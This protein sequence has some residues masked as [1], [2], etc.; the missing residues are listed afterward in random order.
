MPRGSSPKVP[1]LYIWGSEKANFEVDITE[2]I[3]EKRQ[4]LLLHHT[5]FEEE[6]VRWALERWKN[7]AG[8]YVESFRR[9]HSADLIRHGL[10][11]HRLRRHASTRRCLR[12]H[13]AG[14][15]RLWPRSLRR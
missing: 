7:D 6:F 13:P 11:L 15:P 3:E 2:V 12:A 14:V 1:L 9:D 10:F 8:R 5:Q 4:A